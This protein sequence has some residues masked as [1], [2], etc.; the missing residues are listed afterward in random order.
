MHIHGNDLNVQ[1]ASLAGVAS[2]R[3]GDAE[4]AARTR[5]RLQNSAQTLEPTALETSD[6]GANLLV[7]QWLSVRH[8]HALAEDEYTPGPS[9]GPAGF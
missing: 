8:N 4:R 7:G 2:Y 1:A 5:R 3:A 6:P 9:T